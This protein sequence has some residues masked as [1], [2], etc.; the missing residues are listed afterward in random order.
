MKE[1]GWFL[2]IAGAVALEALTA[3]GT[4]LNGQGWQ[5]SRSGSPGMVHFTLERSRPG[6]RMVTSS[7][8]SLTHF[9]GFSPDMLEHSGPVKFS[10]I[11]DAATLQCEGKISWGRGV[12]SFTVSANPAF[13]IGRAHV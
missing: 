5:L 11:Q 3:P 8:V 6:N 10:Y 2:V 9:Q 7:D 13:Q 4:A 1:I 12:G